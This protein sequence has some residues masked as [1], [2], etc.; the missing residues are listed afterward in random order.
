MLD[1]T[2][3]NRFE[4]FF[5]AEEYLKMYLEADDQSNEDIL[6]NSIVI[7]FVDGFTIDPAIYRFFAELLRRRG[8]SPTI[9]ESNVDSIVYVA[10]RDLN[11]DYEYNMMTAR[12]LHGWLSFYIGPREAFNGFDVILLTEEIG[13]EYH[14]DALMGNEWFNIIENRVRDFS[15]HQA[16]FVDEK[17]AQLAL[18]PEETEKLEFGRYFPGLAD[19]HGFE[20]VDEFEGRLAKE[21]QRIN[22]SLGGGSVRFH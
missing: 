10:V 13:P 16:I 20:T 15:D 5:R 18:K 19:W 21:A 8:Y 14:Y 1:N 2:K 22:E 6:V 3:K 7:R 4:G 12:I 9:V 17:T 11:P